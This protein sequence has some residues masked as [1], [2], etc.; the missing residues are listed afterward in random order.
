MCIASWPQILRNSRPRPCSERSRC[1][2]I[3][4]VFAGA[5]R[6][7][8]QLVCAKSPRQREAPA[9]CRAFGA[10]PLR[11]YAGSFGFSPRAP[12]CRKRTFDSRPPTRLTRCWFGVSHCRPFARRFSWFADTPHHGLD[13][14]VDTFFFVSVHDAESE[15][16]LVLGPLADA[17]GQLSA[18]IVFDERGLVAAFLRIPGVHPQRAEV[19]C[20]A[21]RTARRGQ[22]VLWFVSGEIRDA[23]Q[24]K[25]GHGADVCRRRAFSHGI[26]QIQFDKAGN[27]PAG[28]RYGLIPW[29]CG[30]RGFG[31]SRR[32][33][34]R[35]ARGDAANQEPIF[36]LVFL[37]LAGILLIGGLHPIGYAAPH[38]FDRNISRELVK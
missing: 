31:G 1:G 10:L 32:S 15:F 11:K 12:W 9:A 30:C 23:I 37:R 7:L 19:A 24:L 38:N 4:T 17:N 34:S 6:L 29:F 35:R 3:R 13:Q 14:A 8:L 18:E 26:R 5:Q 2:T 33:L 25:P 28:N 20:R 22:E 27:H 36:A 16:G 21:L